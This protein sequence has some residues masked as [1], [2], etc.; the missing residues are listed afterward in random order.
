MIAG[1]IDSGI[2]VDSPEF[3]GKIHPLSGD[4]AGNRGLQ[5]EGGH[6]SAVSAVLLAAKNDT[7]THGI[8]FGATL[9]V[10]R[11]DTAGTCATTEPDKGCTHSDNNM[12]RAVDRAVQA[13]A[14]VINMS[15]GGSPMNATLRAAVDRATAAGIIFVISAG[16]DFDTEPATAINPDPMAMIAIDPI[17]RGQI[18]IAGATDSTQ[19]IS[20]FSNR[21]GTG[22]N[23]YLTALGVR[24]RA[25]DETGAQFLWSGTSFSAPIIAGAVALLAQAFPNLTSQQIVNLLLTTATDL[26]TSGIDNIYGRGELNIAKAFQPVGSASIAG[27]PIPVPTSATGTLGGPLGDAGGNQGP[28]SIILDSYGRAFNAD[29]SGTMRAARAAPK[30]APALAIG[31]NTQIAANSNFAVTLSVAQRRDGVGPDR[32]DLSPRERVQARAVAGAVIARLGQDRQ[33]GIGIARSSGAL[34]GQMTVDRAAA[35]IAADAAQDSLGFFV[36]PA[37][38]FAYRQTRGAFGWT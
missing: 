32:L 4:F 14:K 18:I 17:A 22:Q 26:G 37:T 16:N 21:A 34:V 2:N 15:L 30:L 13:G 29:F 3:S 27:T 11:T 1:V 33:A 5:D 7:D 36:R 10:L 12:A 23:F 35:F 19:A 9:L 6:G 24:V 38:A 31:M 20:A 8:A 28:K 25:P